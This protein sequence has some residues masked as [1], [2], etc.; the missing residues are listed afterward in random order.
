MGIKTIIWINQGT[1]KNKTKY[2]I[3]DIFTTRQ[4]AVWIAQYH[5]KKNK[6]KYFIIEYEEGFWF[7]YKMYALYLNNIKT[8]ESI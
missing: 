7:P 5:K 1:K 4:E 3:Y 8:K 6:S 2:Y